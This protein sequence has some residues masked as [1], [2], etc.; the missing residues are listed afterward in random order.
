MWQHR[1]PEVW[2][3]KYSLNIHSP[4]SC[5]SDSPLARSHQEL[6]G[7]STR[8]SKS[9]VG[10]H[11]TPP[12]LRLRSHCQASWR[13]ASPPNT[14]VSCRSDSRPSSWPKLEASPRSTQQPMDWPAMQGQQQHAT[15]WPM[16]KIHHTWSYGSDATVLDDY[17]LTTTTV[18]YPLVQYPVSLI[19][20]DCRRVKRCLLHAVV[21]VVLW[22]LGIYTTRQSCLLLLTTAIGQYHTWCIHSFIAYPGQ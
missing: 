15:S 7:H 16:E 11:H 10:S 19:I 9:G 5:L 3:W 8:R 17:A 20:V 6:R 12:E 14:P 4:I 18:R 21:S 13:H 2:I 1:L 22:R